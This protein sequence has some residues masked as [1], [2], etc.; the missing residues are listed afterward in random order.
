MQSASAP[1]C[2]ICGREAPI[3]YRGVLPYCTAC[4]G[5]RAPLSSPSVN[6]A[7]KPSRVGGTFTSV[8]GWL[9]LCGGGAFAVSVTLLAFALGAGTVGLAIALPVLVIAL[10]VGIALIKSGRALRG[11]GVEA[12]RATREQAVLALAAH[13]GGI[14]AFDAARSLNIGSVEADA[15]LTALAKRE[16]DRVSVDVDD[17]GAVWYR[18][19]AGPGEP[20]PRAR[21]APEAGNV[22]VGDPGEVETFDELGNPV[23]TR[24]PR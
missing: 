16:P 5:L 15:L 2:P 14:T 4:G 24:A 20:L 6:L 9:A 23:A 19:A 13:R 17:Q 3:V 11:A 10:V 8:L 12:E 22:R 21:V 1:P 7:G 18:V